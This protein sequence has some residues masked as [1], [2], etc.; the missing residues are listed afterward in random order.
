MFSVG[1]GGSYSIGDCG[2]QKRRD[3]LVALLVLFEYMIMFGVG[4]GGG[5]IPS[6]TAG[7]RS[8][9]TH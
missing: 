1:V 2:K 4:V 9:E 5:P 6:V 8:V 7:S 3:S